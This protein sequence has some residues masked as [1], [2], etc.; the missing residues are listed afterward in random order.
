MA[1]QGLLSKAVPTVV[2]G[3]VGAAAYE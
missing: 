3:L 1:W 2:T